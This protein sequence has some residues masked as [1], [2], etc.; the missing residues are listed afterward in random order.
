MQ[1]VIAVKPS[2]AQSIAHVIGA[3]ERKEGYMEGNGYI[4]SWC[5]G[6]LVGLAAADAYDAWYSKWV[7]EDMEPVHDRMPLILER[8]EAVD[9]LLEDG[10]AEELLRKLP[11]MLEHRTEYEQMSI[12]GI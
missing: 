4:V 11:P 5:V 10:A 9:W 7:L 8:E 12:F 3:D 2:V 6:H 1:L